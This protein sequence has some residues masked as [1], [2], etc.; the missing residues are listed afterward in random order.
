[1]TLEFLNNG[2][3]Y[4]WTRYRFNIVCSCSIMFAPPPLIFLSYCWFLSSWMR[5][6]VLQH[7]QLQTTY[8]F[9]PTDT[10]YH[11]FIVLK[12]RFHILFI[13]T[14]RQDKKSL[15]GPV[16]NLNKSENPELPLNFSKPP[17]IV[18]S[19]DEAQKMENKQA[20]NSLMQSCCKL[21]IVCLQGKCVIY[22]YRPVT[23]WRDA[24]Q[25][26]RPGVYNQHLEI[27]ENTLTQFLQTKIP[28]KNS[29]RLL[30]HC[31][32]CLMNKAWL[33]CFCAQGYKRVWG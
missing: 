14:V 28:T 20:C 23:K 13:V 11:L 27:F 17:I 6:V 2:K 7:Y 29:H 25:C 5:C 32:C 18:H 8:S 22:K 15:I 9:H 12:S 30:L 3:F 24:S 26:D 4:C 19:R 16:G 10:Q 1:M 31:Q 21:P 33:I